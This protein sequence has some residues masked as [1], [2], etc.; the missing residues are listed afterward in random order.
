MIGSA[1]FWFRIRRWVLLDPWVTC[2]AALH[3][4]MM[5]CPPGTRRR[6]GGGGGAA[7]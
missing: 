6:R 2:L 4:A 1:L 3:E 7:A 5:R